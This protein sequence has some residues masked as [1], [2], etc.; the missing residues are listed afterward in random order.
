MQRLYRLNYRGLS[1]EKMIIRVEFS[2][3]ERSFIFDDFN[4][5]FLRHSQIQEKLSIY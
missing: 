1:L 3:S 4:I 5:L 2:I